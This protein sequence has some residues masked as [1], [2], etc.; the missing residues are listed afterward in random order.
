MALAFDTD[1]IGTADRM[2]AI[3]A[4]FA[5]ASAPAFVTRE[6]TGTDP[7][8]RMD[9]WHTGP[10]ELFRGQMAGIRL[11]R[12]AT[13]ISRESSP[14][15][16]LAVQQAGYARHEQ[17]GRQRVIAPGDLLATDLNSP[18]DYVF[19]D[20][21]VAQALHVPLDSVDLGY[22]LLRRACVTAAENPLRGVLAQHINEVSPA[23]RAVGP[24]VADQLGTATI[25]LV[26]AFVLTASDRPQARDALAGTLGVRVHGYVRQHLR[27]PTLTPQSIARAHSVSVRQ[28]YKVTAELHD[29]G[30]AH[31]ITTQRLAG[32]HHELADPNCRH[33]SI[34]M[35]ARSWGF[36]SAP[37]FSRRFRRAYGMTPREWRE[38]S[39]TVEREPGP[40]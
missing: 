3:V 4:A 6:G 20:A 40:G 25:E 30:L 36:V 1:L 21:G 18:Y 15:F 22:G 10:A 9:V 19:T 32:A 34:A 11:R 35:I 27:D 38:L 7:R 26:R 5:E 28:L 2:D 14:M 37:H 29:G 13:Q 33:R 16:A 39:D 23:S 17:H 8:V 31:W 24:L 12:T